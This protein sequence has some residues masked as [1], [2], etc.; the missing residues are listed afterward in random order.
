VFGQVLLAGASTFSVGNSQIRSGNLPG[1]IDNT[2]GTVLLADTGFNTVV[3]GNVATT[4]GVGAMYYTQLTYT[5]P[6]QGMPGSAILL[7]GSG[8]GSPGPTRGHRPRGRGRADGCGGG[9][10]DRRDR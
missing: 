1:V 5:I 2:S 6:G 3:A 8:S 9:R 4:D 10:V 7:P